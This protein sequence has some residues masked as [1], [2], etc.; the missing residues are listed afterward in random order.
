MKTMITHKFNTV[1]D[2]VNSLLWLRG[3]VTKSTLRD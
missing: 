1:L 2:L 3:T